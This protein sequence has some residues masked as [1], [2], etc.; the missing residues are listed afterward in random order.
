MDLFLKYAVMAVM[1]SCC[2]GFVAD[3]R[4]RDLSGKNVGIHMPEDTSR[5]A[6][7]PFFRKDSVVVL[8][9]SYFNNEKHKN[10]AGELVSSHYKWEQRDYGGYSRWGEVVRQSGGAIRPS[11]LPPNYK[12]L[13]QAAVYIITDPDIPK[14]NADARY[15]NETY[16]RKIATWVKKGGVLVLLGNDKGNADIRHFNL[17][18]EKFGFLFNEDSYNKVPGRSFDPGEIFIKKGNP[19]FKKVRRV[20]IKELATIKVIDKEVSTVLE[21]KGHVIAVKR[22]FGKGIVF[23]VGDPWFYNEYVNGRLPDTFDNEKAMRA[24]TNWML[25]KAR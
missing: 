12:T 13:S 17:L 5:E 15:M 11:F 6:D 22:H 1:L 4:T 16:A 18:A 2:T 10:K 8:L 7:S 9:D 21:K 20:Y 19:V 25:S 23:A 24:F 3:A 14:E